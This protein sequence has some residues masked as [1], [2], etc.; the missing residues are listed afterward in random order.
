MALN[1]KSGEISKNIM[2]KTGSNGNFVRLTGHK[3][4]VIIG[5]VKEL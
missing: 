2:G 1:G 5:N 3:N 4:D